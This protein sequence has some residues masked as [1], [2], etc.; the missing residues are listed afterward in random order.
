MGEITDIIDLYI[1][2][3]DIIE[4]RASEI[5]HS[6]EENIKGIIAPGFVG[7]DTGH[8]HDS[9]VSDYEVDGNIGVVMAWYGADYGQYWYRWIGGM[10]FMQEGLE[11]TLKL[12]GG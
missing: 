2:D 7:Y 1:E 4:D 8:L 12:Y 5:S 10:D 3:S 6:L 11:Q 9:I